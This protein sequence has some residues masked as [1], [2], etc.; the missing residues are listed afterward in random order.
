MYFPRKT[1]L[2][3]QISI[4]KVVDKEIYPV[5]HK[6]KMSR[7]VTAII[8]MCLCVIMCPI[9]SSLSS[10][11]VPSSLTSTSTF[12]LRSTLIHCKYHLN[13]LQEVKMLVPVYC[14]FNDNQYSNSL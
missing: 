9:C 12:H 4:L 14:G 8:Y 1:K 11:T 6:F 3:Q 5:T 10:L 13:F 7:R 2:K